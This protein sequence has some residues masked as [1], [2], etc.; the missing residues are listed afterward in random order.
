MREEHERLGDPDAAVIGGLART[1]RL[2]TG[3]ALILFLAF[4]SLAMAPATEVKMVG[5]ALGAGILLDAT[6]IRALLVPAVISLLG[7]SAWWLPGRRGSGGAPRPPVG[8]A[9]YGA[10]PAVEGSHRRG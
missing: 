9:E 2:I 5:T 6:V 4:L 1:G 7:R 10:G 3:A 8:R